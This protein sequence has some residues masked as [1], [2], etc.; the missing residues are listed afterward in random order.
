MMSGHG[1]DWFSGAASIAAPCP[2]GLATGLLDFFQGPNAPAWGQVVPRVLYHETLHLWQFAGTRWL[3]RMVIEEWER[4]AALEQDGAAPPPGPLRHGFAR[5]VTG[6]PFAVRDLV[7]C[8]A[9]SWDVH[10]RGAHR[11]REEEGL[12]L[13]PVAA[14]VEAVRE[15]LGFGGY[16]AQ[17]FDALMLR[18]R[19]QALYAAPYAWLLERC[20]AAPLVRAIAGDGPVAPAAS[21]A[22][23]MVLP[24]AGFMALNTDQPVAAFLLGVERLLT[25]EG[26]GTAHAQRNPWGSINLDWLGF[27]SVLAG[28]VGRALARRGLPPRIGTDLLADPALARHPVWRHLPARFEALR[29]SLVLDARLGG[30]PPAEMPPPLAKGLEL[31]RALFAAEPWA[32]FGLPGQPEARAHLGVAFAPPL[33]RFADAEL[34]ATA[35]AAWFAQWP[36]EAA[37]LAAAVREAETRLDALRAADAARR[38]GLPPGAFTLPRMAAAPP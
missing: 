5:P 35:S 33:M 8:L 2:A 22:A 38:F 37:A 4:V 32:L 3:Q 29:R 31:S 27:W 21:W 12:D 23:A 20:A 10:T 30:P 24:I 18:G 1:F 25:P 11:L 16:A 28:G 36:V 19:D 6:E 34:T 9:R 15:R 13:G 26:L 14:R 7:E 17:E